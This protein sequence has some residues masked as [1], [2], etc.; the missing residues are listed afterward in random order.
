[1]VSLLHTQHGIS[2]EN[3]QTIIATTTAHPTPKADDL[4]NS[5]AK[6]LDIDG[7]GDRR[8]S[9]E[10]ALDYLETKASL[11][12]TLLQQSTDW[13]SAMDTNG[14]GLL[15]PA[16]L[17]WSLGPEDVH[18]RRFLVEPTQRLSKEFTLLSGEHESVGGILWRTSFAS[19]VGIVAQ[20]YS[21]N[22][23]YSRS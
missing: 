10:E 22:Q 12:R 20:M 21:S 19:F 1:M 8:I 11:N 23:A 4:R 16:E 2:N 18:P 15:K 6:F 17:D 13:W 3:L 14:D 5:K 9:F 7:D